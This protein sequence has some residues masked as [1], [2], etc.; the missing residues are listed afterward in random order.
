MVASG[1]PWQL[2]TTFDEWGEGTSIEPASEWGM[3]YLDALAA[4]P[5][6]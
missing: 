6:P 1:E 5:V 2:I 3:A 4:N